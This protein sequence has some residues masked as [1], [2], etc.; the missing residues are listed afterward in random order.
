MSLTSVVGGPGA[1]RL[2]LATFVVL[3]HM[4]YLEIGRPAVFVFFMLSGYWVMRMYDEKY[5]PNVSISTFYLSRF[6]RI[7]LPFIC[8][9]LIVFAIYAMIGAAKPMT[10]LKGVPLLGLATTKYDVLG[11]AW[12]LDIEMQFYLLVPLLAVMMTWIGPRYGRRV[13]ALAVAVLLTTL[14]WYLQLSHGVWTVFSYL[15]SF[16]IGVLIWRLRATGSGRMAAL[17]VAAFIAIGIGVALTP[18][19]RPLLLRDVV[20]PFHEDWFGMAWTALL[21]PFVIWNVQQKSSPLDMHFGNYSYALYI[22]HWPVIAIARPYLAPISPADRVLIL[23][24]IALVSILFYVAVDRNCEKLR[25][26]VMQKRLRPR[27]V[28]AMVQR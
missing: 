10:I 11:T 23:G 7:W 17:G 19:L 2:Y 8:A 25:R 6:L 27:L 28:T 18:S 13:A 20:S 15:P 16:V 3:S 22:T 14:G 9:F 4:S 5:A 1:F 26:R 21:I 12:S 24:L